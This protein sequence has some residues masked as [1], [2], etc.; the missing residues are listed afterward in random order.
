MLKLRLFGGKGE[1]S[2]KDV[3]KM[4]GKNLVKMYRKYDVHTEC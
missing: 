1:K 4:Y 3:G 2:G